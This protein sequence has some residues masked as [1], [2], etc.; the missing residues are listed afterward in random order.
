MTTATRGGGVAIAVPGGGTNVITFAAMLYAI[1][2]RLHAAG[3]PVLGIVGSS[4][5]GLACLA[6]AFAVDEERLQ[7]Q[8]EGAC[9][10]NR[11]ISGNPLNLLTRGAW[12]TTAELRR[13]AELILPPKATLGQAKIP[14]GVVVGD[15]WTGA[16]RVIS[17]WEHPNANAVDAGV[18]TASIPYVFEAGRIRGVDDHDC[19]DG[20]LS[21]NLHSEAMDRFRCP[22]ISIRPLIKPAKPAKPK[23]ALGR[24]MANA[25]LLHHAANH[26]WDSDHPQSVYVDVPVS[27]GF[28]F[29]LDRP[30]C[31]RRRN[32]GERAG[33]ECRLPGGI[34]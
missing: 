11:L 3:V 15:Q 8:L 14:V 30:E 9:S 24:L 20:G 21:A 18:V 22:V 27:D 17:S 25:R 12:A 32:V 13:N 23:G 19:V 26:A 33:R 34:P 29:D 28:D 10:R 6:A 31:L 5:G 2:R 7:A 4:A 1:I 16:P